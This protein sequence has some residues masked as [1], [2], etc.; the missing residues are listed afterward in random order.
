MFGIAERSH[1]HFHAFAGAGECECVVAGDRY[2]REHCRWD[3]SGCGAGY[4]GAAFPTGS[5]ITGGATGSRLQRHT[6]GDDLSKCYCGAK[7]DVQ[8]VVFAGWNIHRDGELELRDYAGCDASGDLRI[9][10]TNG[11][12]ER[13]CGADGYCNRRNDGAGDDYF[14]ARGVAWWI[15]AG[16]DTGG[17]AARLATDAEAETDRDAGGAAGYG[18][19]YALGWVR[20]RREQRAAAPYDSGNTGGN[21]HGDGHG[22]FRQSRPHDGSSGGSAVGKISTKLSFQ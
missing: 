11:G 18:S 10:G 14:G 19:A 13:H 21:V 1:L 3:L 20:Q 6:P 8:F 12:A 15:A 4:I 22:N 5:A 16:I 17:R 7:R 2:D 9:F